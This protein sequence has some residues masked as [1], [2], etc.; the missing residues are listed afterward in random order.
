MWLPYIAAK[1]LVIKSTVVI[2]YILYMIKWQWSL[3]QVFNFKFN[4]VEKKRKLAT[5]LSSTES[6]E[7]SR[8]NL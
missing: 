4:K 8:Y 7:K 2:F 1:T 3:S 5:L 6:T